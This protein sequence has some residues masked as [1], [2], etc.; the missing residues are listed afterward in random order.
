MRH[1]TDKCREE[2]RVRRV[3]GRKRTLASLRYI[4]ADLA[5]V[6]DQLFCEEGKG[7]E[8]KAWVVK[9]I[10]RYLRTPAKEKLDEEIVD[11]LIELA[12]DEL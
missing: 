7:P 11:Y 9:Q 2:R 8:R 3:N 12:V 6:A 4:I 10:D 1:V 5:G